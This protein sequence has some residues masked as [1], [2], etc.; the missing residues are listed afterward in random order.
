MALDYVKFQRGTPADYDILLKRDR[1]EDNTLYFLYEVGATTGSLYLGKILIGNVGTGTSITTL[2]DLSDVLIENVGATDILAY[3]SDG[4]WKNASL[5]E[6]A[7]LIAGQQGLGFEI[8]SNIFEFQTVDGVK[9]LKLLGFDVAAEGSMPFKDVNGT[10][11]W[12][13]NNIDI[14]AQQVNDLNN[15][16]EQAEKKIA[17]QIAAAN[18]LTYQTV[19]KLEDRS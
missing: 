14:I 1:V 7:N 6:I 11:A 12:S 16:L 2:S 4:K 10:L 15:A 18:H 3:S 19:E 9:N 5:S 17:E 8:D 13:T